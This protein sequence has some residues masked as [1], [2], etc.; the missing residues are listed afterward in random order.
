MFL[1]EFTSF[2][3]YFKIKKCNKYFV[4]IGRLLSEQITSPH[5]SEE[6]LGDRSNVLFEFSPVR[7]DHIDSIIKHLKSKSSNG[8]DKILNNLIK[9]HLTLIVNQVLHTGIFPRQLKLLRAKPMHKSCEQSHFCNYRPI[10]LYHM[11]HQCLKYF[12]ML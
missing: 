8:F 9:Q 3:I 10:Y 12:N 7:E 2:L 4:N 11:Y 1:E 5:A 6:Y